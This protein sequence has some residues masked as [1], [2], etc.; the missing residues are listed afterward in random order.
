MGDWILIIDAD[1]RL[2]PE[3]GVL[4]RENLAAVDPSCDHLYFTTRNLSG[5]GGTL[6]E[7]THI[8]M[9]RNGR[10]IH[11]KGIVHNQA[12][13]KGR[14]A[15]LPVTLLHYGYALSPEKMEQKYRRTLSLIR[16]QLRAEPEN[17][18]YHHNLCLSLANHGDYAETVKTGLS[19]LNLF[20]QPFP[21]TYYNLIY[22]IASSALALG[23]AEQALVVSRQAL[24]TEPMHLDSLW[25]LTMASYRIGAYDQAVEY[26]ER[27]AREIAAYR[28]NPLRPLPVNTL[29]QV[30]PLLATTGYSAALCDRSDLALR[31]FRKALQESDWNIDIA[32]KI[33]HFCKN[34]GQRATGQALLARLQERHPEHPALQ[35]FSAAF[36]SLQEE[37]NDQTES[38]PAPGAG[39]V[40]IINLCEL[41]DLIQA[42]PLIEEL[43]ARNMT[44]TLLVRKDREETARHLPHVGRIISLNMDHLDGREEN[45]FTADEEIRDRIGDLLDES[46]DLLL[47]MTHTR[48]GAQIARMARGKHKQ[49]MLQTE[50]NQLRIRGE[51][52]RYLKQ[53]LTH[54]ELNNLH[55]VDLHRLL[56][57]EPLEKRELSFQISEEE[58]AEA[59]EMLQAAGISP[60]TPLIGIQPGAKEA[61]KRWPEE[62]YARLAKKIAADRKETLL[63]FGVASEA[64]P[65]SRIEAAA[66]GRVVNFTGKTGLGTLAA[67]LSRCRVLISNDTGTSHLAAAVGTKVLSLHLGHVWFRETAPYG[68]GHV[69]LQVKTDCSPCSPQKTCTDFSCHRELT[70]ETVYHVLRMMLEGGRLPAEQIPPHLGIYRSGFDRQNFLNHQ[71]LLPGNDN[72][73]DTLRELYGRLWQERLTGRKEEVPKFDERDE[74]FFRTE[75]KSHHFLESFRRLKEKMDEALEVASTLAAASRNGEAVSEGARR[76]KELHAAIGELGRQAPLLRPL[77]EYYE[78]GHQQIEAGNFPEVMQ[79]F[80]TV[81]KNGC[82]LLKELKEILPADRFTDSPSKSSGETAM[83]LKTAGFPQIDPNSQA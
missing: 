7:C 66:P 30:P 4:L 2:R 5:K 11:Y 69:A 41:G 36:A 31:F 56:L 1:E 75:E 50:G 73:I 34:R 14:G 65:A 17:P 68:E 27:Y 21:P 70:P 71:S 55:V 83:S 79:A 80:A 3:D 37:E 74:I 22:L 15:Y 67:L 32:V 42:T 81:L 76:F 64:L 29:G 52:I 45:G 48:L 39:S 35:P 25:I 77:T 24:E 62:S 59:M 6:S 18:L 60:E 28:R 78:I 20:T 54:R 19:A 9:F 13:P 46:F 16:R 10:G 26:G 43:A 44:V 49:G 38:P 47:N 33:L 58:W 72:F 53:M 63:L 8:R 23:D 57:E 61:R 12:V 51:A 40:L 82:N